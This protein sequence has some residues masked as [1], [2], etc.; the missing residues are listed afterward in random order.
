[1][2][3]LLFEDFTHFDLLPFCFT[4][5]VYAIRSGIMTFEERWKTVLGDSVG[6]IAYDYLGDKYNRLPEGE[7]IAVNGKFIPDEAML[8]L[9]K[10]IPEGVYFE[11]EKGEVLAFRGKDISIFENG[12]LK[13]EILE[14]KGF[15]GEKSGLDGIAIRKMQD[16]FR[17]NAAL[18][19]FDF[20]W[21]T[22]HRKSQ[23]ITDTYSPVYGRDNIF[24]E[25]GVKIR[26]AILNA[27]DGLMYLGKGV[28][29]QEGAIIHGTHA[30]GEYAVANMGAKLRGDST[31][32]P[33]VK[34]GGEVG[35]SVIMG[36]S[37]KGH[38]G[39]LGNSVLGYW[40]NL[41]ADTN[42]SNLKNTYENV[43]IWNYV[44]RRFET[45]GSQFCG[46]MMGDHSKCGINTMFNT[47]TVVGVSA[48]VF[49]DGFPRN[50][51]PDFSWG[52]AAGFTT[53]K[54]D[55]VFQTAEA[56]MSRRKIELDE[57]EKAILRN[58]FELTKE[59]RSW[60]ANAHPSNP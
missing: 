44:S 35:N 34:V 1:M 43:R 36:Y 7:F 52:G 18:I 20:E 16:I 23:P 41:G 30:F 24:L 10:E 3:Y 39:Y 57:T 51:I 25:E 13:K 32:G 9:L 40:C 55:K 15:R 37:N 19:R 11:N 49:G 12:L 29:I 8:R 60:E 59:Y 21:I 54:L 5:P 31:F 22:R 17:N 14:S 53:Y 6:S 47:G 46:L 42:T 50:F 28:D 38:D 48:N 45:T 4:R 2:K 26:A 33:H 56:V 58:V 27:E